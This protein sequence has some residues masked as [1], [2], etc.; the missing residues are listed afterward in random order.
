MFS[1]SDVIR[2]TAKT[3]TL[4]HSL[5]SQHHH[6]S[7][8][9]SQFTAS[10]EQVKNQLTLVAKVYTAISKNVN[11]Q[12]KKYLTTLMPDAEAGCEIEIPHFG[13]IICTNSEKISF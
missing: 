5:H 4:T 2:L 12:L 13:A 10:S 1:Y 3:L 6:A 7:S 9:Q 8:T 11:Y